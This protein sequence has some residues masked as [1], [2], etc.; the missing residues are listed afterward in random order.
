MA[1]RLVSQAQEN[2]LIS[3]LVKTEID[4][5]PNANLVDLIINRTEQDIQLEITI[6]SSV[7]PRHSQ[8][9]SLQQALVSRLEKP[10]SLT[11]THIRSDILAPLLPPTN[12]PTSTL[13]PSPTFT[14]TPTPRSTATAMPT[15]TNTA[16]ETATPTPTSTSIP[17]T[18]TPRMAFVVNTGM[19]P[20]YNLYQEPGGPIIARLL[21]NA[22]LLDLHENT[23]FEGLVW[24]KVMDDEGRIGWFPQRYLQYPSPTP[25][26]TATSPE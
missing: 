12:T 14:T 23:T 10:V 22:T 4:E 7:Q 15:V 3:T 20:Y 9:L 17:P 8:V 25:T 13:G 18:P 11:V 2:R 16:T 26:L 5:I 24:T 6:R 21:L 1:A 19:V